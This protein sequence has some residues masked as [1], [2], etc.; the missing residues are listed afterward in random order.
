[1]LHCR[2][3][4]GAEAAS[5]ATLAGLAI[6]TEGYLAMDGIVVLTDGV[7]G[8]AELMGRRPRRVSALRSGSAGFRFPLD[9]VMV[10]VRWYLRYGLSYRD[11]IDV[12]VAEKRD[13]AA[14]G[15]FFSRARGP[16][17]GYWMSCCPLPAMSWRGTRII[18]SNPIMDG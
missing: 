8:Q 4:A 6:A 2:G 3:H 17:H 15:R 10:A 9:V 12:L 1:M 13:L 14:T 7:L 18:R 16:A 11:V 5:D